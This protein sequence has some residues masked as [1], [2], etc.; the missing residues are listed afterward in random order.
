M[1]SGT[2]GFGPFSADFPGTLAGNWIETGAARHELVPIWDAN[3]TVVSFTH[4]A[5]PLESLDVM[6]IIS[7]KVGFFCILHS[8]RITVWSMTNYF[9][10]ILLPC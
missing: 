2:E 5:S 10:K 9:T 4:Y 8:V 7:L 1:D 3:V 6:D